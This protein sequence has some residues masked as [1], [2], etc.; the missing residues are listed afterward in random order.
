MPP[1][2][3]LNYM[4]PNERVRPRGGV[5]VSSTRSLTSALDGVEFNATARPLYPREIPGTHCIGNW[6]GPGP[7]WTGAKYHATTGIN[8]R[9]VWP[10]ARRYTDWAMPSHAK[11][12][13][14]G[15]FF[16]RCCLEP[17]DGIYISKLHN[18][19]DS[20]QMSFHAFFW[21]MQTSPNLFI[22]NAGVY[23]VIFACGSFLW[24]ASN[25][26]RFLNDLSYSQDQG[27]A[28]VSDPS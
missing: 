28:L 24:T 9:T 5:E 13:K 17:P 20:C 27:R 25:L 2:L 15:K 7:V 21:N 6:V 16:L 19:A 22:P 11:G 10:L 1:L 26:A 14:S 4:M 3:R 23:A 18:M 8:P 12:N